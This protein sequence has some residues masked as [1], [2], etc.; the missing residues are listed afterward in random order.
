MLFNGE[1]RGLRHDQTLYAIS[2]NGTAE[3]FQEDPVQD[4]VSP[5]FVISYAT[6]LPHIR[7]A[8]QPENGDRF[9]MP[10]NSRRITPGV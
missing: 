3:A 5:E 8:P 10:A 2:C 1:G 4:C 7:G 9:D 6:F